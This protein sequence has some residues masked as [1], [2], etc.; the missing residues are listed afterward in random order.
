MANRPLTGHL[1]Q[2]LSVDEILEMGTQIADALDAAH[3]KGM[4]HRDIKP[5][6]IFLTDAGSVKVLDFGL[7]K[8]IAGQA[9][10][11]TLDELATVD[12]VDLTRTGSA[13]GTVAYMSPEQV[14]GEEL[15]PRSDLFSF[16][17]VLY[18][19]ATGRQPFSGGTS[20]VVFEAILNRT[21]TAPIHLNPDV[22]VQLEA[23]IN[24]SLEKSRDLRYHHASDIRSDIRRLRRDTDSGFSAATTAVPAYPPGAP[25]GRK[26]VMGIVAGAVVLL[27][28]IFI[29]ALQ[30]RGPAALEESDLILLTDFENSTG[31]PVFD[32]TPKQ[33]LALNLAESPFLNV[34]SDTRV[35][36]TLRF[37][38]RPPDERVTAEIGREICE[39]E[40]IKAMMTGEIVMLGSTYVLT[41]TALNCVTG[42]TIAAE[43]TQAESKEQVLSVLGTAVASMR[44]KLGESLPMIESFSTPI[45]QATTSSLDALKSFS[46][47]DA[48]RAMG[49][50]AESAPFYRR[51][52]ELDPEFAVAYAR[53]GTVLN[54]RGDLEGAIENYGKAFELKDRAGER[55]RFY[56]TGHYYNTVEQDTEK[57]IETYNL[58]RETYPRDSTPSANL[59]SIYSRRGQFDRVAEW[60]RISIEL[61][62]HPIP[63]NHLVNAYSSLGRPDEELETLEEWMDEFPDDGT[64]HSQ[65]AFYKLR[66]GAFEEGLREAQLAYRAESS[67]QHLQSLILANLCLNRIAE[68]RSIADDAIEANPNSI[69]ARIQA[70]A[71]AQLDRDEAVAAAHVEWSRGQ[72]GEHF[73]WGLEATILGLLGRVRESAAMFERALEVPKDRGRSLGL[74]DI[75]GIYFIAGYR[76]RALEAVESAL[77]EDVPLRFKLGV[78]AL[79]ALLGENSESEKLAAQMGDQY[80]SDDVMQ[81]AV[82]PAIRALIAINRS[83][84]EKAL[85]LL[86]DAD[87]FARAEPVVNYV[88]GLAYSRTG[89]LDEALAEFQQILDNP[90]TAFLSTGNA[91]VR[92]LASFEK[93]RL[94]VQAERGVAARQAY[95]QIFAHWGGADP[96][97][98]WLLEL[99]EEYAELN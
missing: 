57:A 84:P 88:R 23:I 94:L 96:D 40:S 91:V 53:L 82:L 2:T 85:E 28:V 70:Y 62:P 59:A 13:V 42:E 43:Q 22:P 11:S 3:Q 15:D 10:A 87:E 90:G 8:T 29:V 37:M 17:L 50:N 97:L 61:E 32:D 19:M 49:R 16:G 9:A 45:E 71:L 92:A 56:L 27:A 74:S 41:L 34:V 76:E 73:M 80:P 48:Q 72:F 93:A 14:R 1:D 4:V 5:A 58:W 65:M 68:A 36:E 20:G 55:E 24:K 83:D 46:M 67:A 44:G 66:R 75:A 7:A 35:R 30:L 78:A 64:S 38:E 25:S 6:N 51:A 47:A 31:E 60:A 63:Y 79:L 12:G 33:A 99:R 39:R 54:N 52:I 89:S 95:E 21:P 26:V 98:P 86:Q 77:R 81:E 18:E 69:G